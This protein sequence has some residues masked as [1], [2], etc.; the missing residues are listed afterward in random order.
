MFFCWQHNA[1]EP[2]LAMDA[3]PFEERCLLLFFAWM[4]PPLSAK[5]SILPQLSAFHPKIRLQKREDD[6][7]CESL[8]AQP[9]MTGVVAF[10][11]DNF[12]HYQCEDE[13]WILYVARSFCVCLLHT[14]RVAPLATIV[15]IW[16]KSCSTVSDF[17][18]T[19]IPVSLFKAFPNALASVKYTDG[20]KTTWIVWNGRGISASINSKLRNL[21][22]NFSR[23]A[24]LS[25]MLNR[26]LSFQCEN[27]FRNHPLTN[28]D[29]TNQDF[30]LNFYREL[31]EMSDVVTE[32]GKATLVV[33]EAPVSS[34]AWKGKT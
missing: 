16:I 19:D 32:N 4:R 18:D 12:A 9:D 29:T 31:R 13:F 3:H 25:S 30:L 6:C 7:P 11:M 21:C 17:I 24:K 22:A 5:P 8:L 20:R 1:V 2:T 33:V 28:A 14:R 26:T 27:E 23:E 10:S 34:I 15:Q